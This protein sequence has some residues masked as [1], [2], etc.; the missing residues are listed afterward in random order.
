MNTITSKENPVLKSA[1]KLLTRKGREEAGALLV[2]GRKLISEAK[3]TGFVIE[4]TFVNAGALL[5]GE[6]V[7]GENEIVLEEKLFRDLAQTVSPQPYIAVV[8]RP[9]ISQARPPSRVLVLDRIGD[10]GNVGTMTR[11]ALA[12]GMDEMWCV[13]GTADAF[14]DKAIRASAGAVFHLTIREGLS[15][16][17]CIGRLRDAGMGLL[18]CESG[19]TDI[20]ETQLP[21]MFA[22]LIGSESGGLAKEFLDA[23]D[24]IVGIPMAEASESLNAAS[25]AAVVMY[26]T[27]RR[28]KSIVN[29]CAEGERV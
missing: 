10:P 22:I 27:L 14:S 6:A 2:E 20:Y 13:K 8:Q 1:R 12:S 5:R 4:H 24:A 26:E 28:R 9:E 7:A 18:V 23:A 19:G 29:D 17:E 21:D 25:A 15:A 3:G 11:T 16:S